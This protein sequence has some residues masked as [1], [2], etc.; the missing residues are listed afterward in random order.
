M[1]AGNLLLSVGILFTG[2]S[3]ANFANVAK[4]TNLQIFSD[5]NFTS[6][7]KK[8]LFPVINKVKTK[9]NNSNGMEL[10]GLKRCLHHLQE[11]WVVISKLATDRH[12]QVRAH[13]AKSVQKNLQKKLRQ[14]VAQNSS[15]GFRQLLLICGGALK[16]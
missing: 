13:M 16:R 4:A 11:E 9:V 8:Y 1:A 3:Y 15:R 7:Q 6:T 10:E 5:R 12:V 2:S 14:S